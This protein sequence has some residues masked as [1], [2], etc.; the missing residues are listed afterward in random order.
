ML[1]GLYHPGSSLLHQSSPRAKV[2]GLLVFT[3]LLVWRSGLPTLTAGLGVVVL[4]AAVARIPPRLLLA[5]VWPLRWWV[6]V[7]VPFQAWSQGWHAAVVF[8][9]TLVVA[10]A[11]A[12]V[13]TLCTRVVDMLDAVI[14]ALQPLRRL[15]VD[16]E[17]V[18]LL[19]A[20]TMRAVPVVTDAFRLS[21]QARAARGLERS[22]RALLTPFVVRVVRHAER[23]GQALAARGVDD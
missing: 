6:L 1:T 4:A 22:P 5:Q 15:G 18:G 16:P 17:R 13:V 14:A 8:V 9:G 7:L 19:L 21:R 11:A 10:V 12:S 20:L 2:T 23:T 3:T